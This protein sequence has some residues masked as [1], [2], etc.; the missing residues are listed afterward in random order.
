MSFRIGFGRL[1]WM[2]GWRWGKFLD[3][4]LV[5]F[6]SVRFGT[7]CF[8]QFSEVIRFFYGYWRLIRIAGCYVKN[9]APRLCILTD[10]FASINVA[11][12]EAASHA[13][14]TARSVTV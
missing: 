10:H 13:N 2:R 4:Y 11:N 7:G 3:L 12:G 6:S 1:F 8:P 9:D 14:G 5:V